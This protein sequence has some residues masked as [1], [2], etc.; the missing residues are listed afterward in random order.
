MKTKQAT[1]EEL[2]KARGLRLTASRRAVVDEALAGDE[3]FSVADMQL[4]LPRL[5]RATVFRTIRLLVD[6]GLLCRVLLEDGT[7]CYR[8]SAAAHHHHLVCTGCGSVEDFAECDLD[9]VSAALAGRTNYAIQGHR[10]ELFGL[11]PTCQVSTS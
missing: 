8:A 3:P 9:A 5:G 2:L 7:P 6:L 4:R 1:I 11:C 10:L